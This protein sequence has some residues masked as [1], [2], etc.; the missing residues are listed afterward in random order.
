MSTKDEQ[1]VVFVVNQNHYAISIHDVSEI[2][3]M[4][5]VKWVPNSREEFLG[6]IHL[7]EQIIPIISLHRV[8]SEKEKTIDSKTRMIVLQTNGQ[9]L[10]FVVDEVDHV[11]FLPDEHISPAPHL[12]QS[13]WING[14]YHHD[15]RTIALLNLQTLLQHV[16]V[17]KALD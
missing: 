12:S 4:Q 5:T 2:I 15:D 7:R 6:V 14:V 17:Q 11:M 16:D 8:F 9:E 1:Y 13:E 10:G 3:R